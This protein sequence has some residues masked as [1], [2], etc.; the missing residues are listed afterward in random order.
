MKTLIAAMG[1]TLLSAGAA[2]A[3]AHLES[4]IPAADTAVSPAPTQLELKF[5]EAVELRF[6]G[7]AITGPADAAVPV[8]KASL[9]A[10][11]GTILSV[12]LS[13]GLSPGK[14]VVV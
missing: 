4:E 11:D 1:L 10:G 2:F 3:H 6:T 5:S 14:Y 7:V 13:G 9:K 8:G 12:P